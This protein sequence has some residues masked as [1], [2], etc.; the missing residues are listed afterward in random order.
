[1]RNTG[2]F[3]MELLGETTFIP[4]IEIEVDSCTKNWGWVGK[5]TGIHVGTN[6]LVEKIIY[7]KI[8]QKIREIV[9]QKETVVK[10]KNGYQKLVFEED[11]KNEE[12]SET[13]ESEENPITEYQELEVFKEDSKN[14]EQSETGESS[15][16]PI[17]D[18]PK[19]EFCFG[20]RSIRYPW[21]YDFS[22][23]RYGDYED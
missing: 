12:Q 18:Y 22:G 10:N 19:K 13:G 9:T 17:T 21:C 7:H 3:F 6:A 23:Y 5:T 11:C 20:E 14:E 8:K 4:V 16:Q 2:I 1:M 15:E